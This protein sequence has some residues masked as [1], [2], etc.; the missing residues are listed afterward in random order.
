MGLDFS[1]A[2]YLPQYD[3]FARPIEVRPAIGAS[4]FNRGIYGTRA[5]LIAA[6]DGSQ[7][8][9]Q[10]TILDIR[11]REFAT[12][13]PRQGDQIFIPRDGNVP[14]AGL[15]EIADLSSNGGGETTLVIR[16]VLEPRP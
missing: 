14:E 2:V 3:V 10:E 16:A 15:F 4:F 12:R 9:D 7:I 1:V 11:E 6:E 13:F 5:V 8:S